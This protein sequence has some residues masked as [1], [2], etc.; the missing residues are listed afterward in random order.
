MSRDYSSHSQR[1]A[2]VVL[3]GFCGDPDELAILTEGAVPYGD[4]GS[5]GKAHA[6]SAAFRF[7]ISNHVWTVDPSD[8]EEPLRYKF[9]QFLK[10]NA[11]HV[12]SEKRQRSRFEAAFETWMEHLPFRFERISSGSPADC[13]AHFYVKRHE[14][15]DF[16][17]SATGIP[18][19]APA[20]AADFPSDNPW[21]PD[22]DLDGKIDLQRDKPAVR[23]VD[24]NRTVDLEIWKD[25]VWVIFGA[26]AVLTFLGPIAWIIAWAIIRKYY[27]PYRNTALHELGHIL[28][29][30]HPGEKH[31]TMS[32]ES[33]KDRYKLH[34]QDVRGVRSLYPKPVQH[35]VTFTPWLPTARTVGM[36]TASHGTSSKVVELPEKRRL[37]AWTSIGF[38]ESLVRF[39]RDNAVFADVFAIGGQEM[40]SSND[41]VD[42][43]EFLVGNGDP[44]S[45]R[46]TSSQAPKIKQEQ[47]VQLTHEY[48]Y[49][50]RKD[51]YWLDYYHVDRS[52]RR[53]GLN[54]E[55]MGGSDGE[56]G[57]AAVYR[58]YGYATGDRVQFRVASVHPKDH[59]AHGTGILLTIPP[60]PLDKG[61]DISVTPKPPPPKPPE[62][63]DVGATMIP[64]IQLPPPPPLG[65]KTATPPAPLGVTT[66]PPPPPP[67][68]VTTPTPPPPPAPLGLATP[69][70]TAVDPG[71][72]T[73]ARD[74]E[75]RCRGDRREVPRASCSERRH[76]RLSW[77]GD[78]ACPGRMP[79]AIDQPAPRRLWRQHCFRRCEPLAHSLVPSGESNV[80]DRRTPEVGEVAARMALDRPMPKNTID[81][82]ASP[83]PP[84][85]PIESD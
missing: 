21:H 23:F 53:L 36:L 63:P 76:A 16:D 11:R 14:Q 26:E 54:L 68:G 18:P 46:E 6:K 42:E 30:G 66:T 69:S 83:R 15:F 50:R 40:I 51:G 28:G 35:A 29:L 1:V 37:L 82:S 56:N 25:V 9:I 27:S 31:S 47:R 45:V 48:R 78:A 43:D 33:P 17:A 79:P 77:S 67:L 85:L 61:L 74:G 39:D 5:P 60:E 41:E 8:P 34:E 13:D 75:N 80:I 64:D 71:F 7:V 19:K 73:G 72:T 55:S 20:C 57:A 52:P 49:V 44:K 3:P 65:F 12:I 4:R 84:E 38:Q 10:W 2:D 59:L 24:K 70:A 32:Y 22:H 62:L 81:H 58:G